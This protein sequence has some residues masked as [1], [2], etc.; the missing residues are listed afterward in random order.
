MRLKHIYITSILLT[1][2]VVFT[3]CS[4]EERSPKLVV[5]VQDSKSVQIEGATVHAWPTDRYHVDSTSSGVP[6]LGMDQ[7]LLTDANGDAAFDFE[8]SAVLDIDVTYLLV[9]SDTTSEE[10]VGHRVVKIETI[11][12]KEKDNIFEETITLE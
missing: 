8:F 7:T 9:T 4:K 10:L 11:K 1:T 5:H 2:I 3:A 12:Q 6:N